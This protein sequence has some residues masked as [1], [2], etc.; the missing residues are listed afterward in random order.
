MGVV[1]GLVPLIAGVWKK[2]QALGA[3][4]F[5][6]CIVGGLI[7]GILLAGPIAVTFT[8][9]IC[10]LRLRPPRVGVSE[11]KVDRAMK[12]MEREIKKRN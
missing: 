8:T 7:F 11:K 9:I 12:Q 5:F 6:A 2:R 4:G 3:T 1:C 10:L